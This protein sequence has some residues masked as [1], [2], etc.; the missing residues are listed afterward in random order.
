MVLR[1]EI[2]LQ[3]KELLKEN[4]QGLSITDIVKVVTINRNTAGRY[5]ENLLISGQVEMRR[6]GMAKIYVLSQR[7]PLS[8][9]LSIS[10]ELVIQLDNS[11]RI[12]FANEP[13]LKLVGTDSKSLLG[14]NIEYTPVAL[15][16][17]E[18]FTGFIE[19]IRAGIAGKEWAGEIILSTKDIILFCRIAPTVFEDGRKGLSVIFEDI[20]QRK[21]TERKIEESERQFRLLAENSIDMISRI[22]PDGTRIYVSPAYK[23]T[24]GYEPEELIGKRGQEFIHPDDAHILASLHNALTPQNPSRTII[25]RTKHKNGH[26]IWI[27]S[28][29]R[30]IFNENTLEFSEYYAVTRD[31][32]ERKMAEISLH[33]SEERY[34]SLVD[35]SPDAVIIHRNGKIIFMNPAALTLIGASQLDEM[36]GK[37]I[38]E[39]IQPEFRDEVMENIQKDLKGDISPQIELHML[40]VDGTPVIVEGRGVKTTIDGKPAVQVAIRD[41]TERKRVEEI[42][43]KNEKQYRS[44]VETT[45]TG[46]VILDKAGRVITANQEYVRL[47]GRSTLAE[48]EERPVTDWTASYDIERNVREIDDCFRK[49][50]VRNFEVDYQKPDGTIQPIEV[51]ASVFQS[52][53]EQIILTLCRDITERKHAEEAL[54][55]SEEKYR[56][57]ID[58]ANDG[59]VVVQDSIIKMCNRYI[60]EFWG[61]SIEEILGRPFTDFIHPDALSEVLDRYNQRMAGENPPSIYQTILK[62]KDG[63]RFYAELNAGI[64][65]YEGKTAD[66]III[67]DMNERKKTADALRD[68]EER[69]RTLAEASNDLIFVIG[70][71]DRVEYVNSYASA[72]VN[73]PVTQIVGS[74]RSSLFPPEVSGNQKKALE[75][76]FE[77]G[78][79]VRNEG[80]LTFAG[81]TH[82][83]DHF[84]TPLKGADNHVRSVLG[85]SRDITERKQAE[86]ALRNSEATA[87]AL[88]NAPTD[89]VILTD[90]QRKILAL[91]ETAALRFGKGS[92]ELVGMRVDDLL[93]KEIMKTRKPLMDQVIEKKTMVHF[94]DERDGRWY[95]TVA[96]PILSET[97]Q[98]N[99]IAIISRD[100]TERKKAEKQLQ[101]NENL[102]RL[103][104]DSTD[105][106]IIMQ[107]PEGR[108]LYL[109]TA[110]IYGMSGEQ[111]IGSTPYDFLER[112]SADRIT[113]RVK[114]IVKTGQNNREETPL[115]WKG[116]RLWFSDSLY[117]VTDDH[118]TITAVL[119]VSQNITE[120]KLAEI[121]LRESEQSFKRLLEQSFDAIA[122]HKQGK[123]TFLN[124]RAAKVLGAAKPED[125]IGRPIFDF[126]HPESRKDLEDRLKEL[127]A[128]EGMSA[129]LITE[130]FIRT[131]GSTVTVEVMAISFDDN[132]IPAF[133]VAFR[134]ISTP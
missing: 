100:F 134:E 90:I 77:T 5:L 41:I 117:P 69:Y 57:L 20:T 54:R 9:V 3:I 121:A 33:E 65:S 110:A 17:D 35:I 1:K 67:R 6:L 105:D 91:N 16:F 44:L 31:I 92:D 81:R 51:N 49:G 24:L 12:I 56:T 125:L 72:L 106:M 111:V 80:A 109:N 63:S 120:R 86:D 60:S 42:L 112:E 15:V 97:G 84:L 83:F 30:A 85:I 75:A 21:H 133:R 8:A 19:N 93:P 78:A 52:D 48:I 131:D 39:F 132:G 27:E 128:T 4:P 126:I 94:E 118:G 10:S 23:T 25:F 108:F 47:T 40:R 74:S 127:S 7:V 114:T 70:K 87:R 96:Y 11:L 18:A 2:A 107:D 99:K 89:S 43:Q 58:R 102:L 62:R 123:I 50:W 129:P 68:S 28:T 26:Y 124:E 38:L 22:K 95:D 104:L 55:E 37:N 76:V 71:D 32:T 66:L 14:K 34:R 29:I 130:K 88:M 116:K 64:I 113:E 59:I 53:S 45:G 82:W 36:L 73:K 79:S 13:F 119:T 98:V 122:I 61:G 46:Y 115:V 101:E 103:I